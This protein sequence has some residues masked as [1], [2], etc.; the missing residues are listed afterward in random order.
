M[1]VIYTKTTGGEGGWRIARFS[2][3]T[4]VGTN[5]YVWSVSNLVTNST[6]DGFKI[7][8]AVESPP[9]PPGGELASDQSDN[10]FTIQGSTTPTETP[11]PTPTPGTSCIPSLSSPANGAVLTSYPTLSW[12]ACEGKLYQVNINQVHIN[13]GGNNANY[14]PISGNSFNTTNFSW[15]VGDSLTWRVRTCDT[16]T[17]SFSTCLNPGTWSSTRTFWWKSGTN[18][19]PTNTPK[20]TK[21]PTPGKATKTPTPGKVTKTPTP[22]KVTKTPTPGGATNTPTPTVGPNATKL[23]FKVQLPD[24]VATTTN[25]PATDVQV[26][27]IDGT[28]LVGVANADLVRNGN[29]FETSTDAAFNINQNIPYTVFVKSKISL[30]RSFAGITL[31][32]SQTL[33]C[34]V[35]SAANCGELI[36]DRDVKLLFSG[37]SDGFNTGSGSYNKIDSADLQ[38]LATYFNQA[39][40]AQASTADFNID[41]RVD[42]SDLEI[43]G[44]NYSQQG[45]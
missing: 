31:T 39:A 33:D 21:T 3:G 42:I 45:D 10:F 24:I 5:S 29:Y 36:T 2:G 18:I 32:Q 4:K 16:G 15:E 41:S 25:I 6:S 19:S 22:G 43:L 23:K 26:E 14:G 20:L 8:V 28:N 13:R 30:G 40:T 34:T 7:L 1:W 38:V 12:S 44:R 11:I 27:L 9:G 17:G 35:A 37:D